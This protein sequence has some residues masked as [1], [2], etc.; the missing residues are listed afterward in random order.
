MQSYE[1]LI[2]ARSGNIKKEFRNYTWA[3]DKNWKKLNEPIDA[4]NH[5][6]D[7]IRYFF[8]MRLSKVFKKKT[9]SVW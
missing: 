7:W 8:M 5:A 4:F 9:V 1:L 2:T 6:I 3:V